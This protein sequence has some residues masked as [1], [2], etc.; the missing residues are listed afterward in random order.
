[1]AKKSGV[2]PKILKWAREQAGLTIDDIAAALR[3]KS[4]VIEA[5]ESESHDS[6]PTY[7]QLEKLAY[8]HY[9]RP[10][11]L[12]FFPAIPPEEDIKKDFRTLPNAEIE[13]LHPDTRYAVRQAKAIQTSLE[14]MTGGINP[15]KELIFKDLRISTSENPA[16]AATIIR[17]YLG[18]S[19]KQQISWKKV[20]YALQVWR[21]VIQ[22][23][24]IYIFKKSFKQNE[25]SG[26]C[27]YEARFPVIYLNNSDADS[28][29]IFSIFH[30][31]AH[32][33]FKTGGIT[34]VDDDYIDLLDGNERDIEVFC[35][36]VA[37]EF[38]V[39]SDDFSTVLPN[40]PRDEEAIEKLA[41]RYKV[42]R[43]VILR[44]LRDRDLV[45]RDFYREMVNKWNSE[46]FV[47]KKS[48]KSKGGNWFA[49]QAT[50]LGQ[51]YLTLAFS[52][53]YQGK[54][55]AYQLADYLNIRQ[56]NLSGLE[57]YIKEAKS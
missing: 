46:Y 41:A 15:S 9:R 18:I 31:L 34:K 14:E 55:T 5:W 36:K 23:K 8:S 1:M 44:R 47:L 16:K 39:P 33:L 26:F 19:L 21:D 51:R 50:Y 56:K 22:D 2:N 20:K 3:K 57:S 13:R 27:V 4:H 6:E 40:N 11:A 53:Y 25:L 43:E 54:A 32:I 42:S 28:R 48:K 12:F 38:L 10:L 45:S 37:A 30:E 7:H 49:T 24:G 29:Q 17:E 35:N 52:K